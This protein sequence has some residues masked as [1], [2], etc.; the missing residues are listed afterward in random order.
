MPPAEAADGP[1]R[2]LF[3]TALDAMYIFD[4]AGAS[5]TPTRPRAGCTACRPRSCGNI[6]C[7]KACFTLAAPRFRP[8]RS[9]SQTTGQ[10]LDTLQ[11]CCADGSM[12]HVE[13]SAT[14]HFLPGRHL[15]VVR[16]VTARVEAD[17]LV[18]E[19][20]RRQAAVATFGQGAWSR[21]TCPPCATRPPPWS[22][23]S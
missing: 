12:R 14:A 16:D 17:E 20:A 13:F 1:F 21:A 8:L 23:P 10:L 2:A 9:A 5:S 3:E 19:R 6:T 18:R 22:P 11:I 15:A 7:A 4:D